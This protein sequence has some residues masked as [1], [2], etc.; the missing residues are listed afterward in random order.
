MECE[1]MSLVQTAQTESQLGGAKT[2]ILKHPQVKPA[3]SLKTIT[4]I[5]DLLNEDD[6][7]SLK[8]L[9]KDIQ[10]LAVRHQ[11]VLMEDRKIINGVAQYS[12]LAVPTSA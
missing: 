7:N 3:E 1:M 4:S 2:L 11:L 6:L 5:F 12:I 8:E 10:L 9:S